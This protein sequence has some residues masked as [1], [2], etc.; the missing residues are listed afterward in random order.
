MRLLWRTAGFCYHEGK[1]ENGAA[2]WSDRGILCSPPCSLTPH[3]KREAEE[4]LLQV[5]ALDPFHIPSRQ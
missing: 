2:Y 3:R 1:V 5:L 4:T